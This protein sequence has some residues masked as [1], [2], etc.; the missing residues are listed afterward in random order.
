MKSKFQAR[1]Y[2]SDLVQKEMNE[3]KFS[4]NWDQNKTKKNSKGVPLV[5]TFHTLLK[6]FANTIQRI[7]I[8]YTST[9]KLKTFHSC[10]HDNFPQCL[11]IPTK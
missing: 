1:G 7:C 6:D 4:S 3:V 10:A 9:K 8:C 2:A 5:I 11:K